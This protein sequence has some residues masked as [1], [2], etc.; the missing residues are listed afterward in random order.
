MSVEQG[1]EDFIFKT[2]YAR[3]FPHLKRR[4]NWSET[5]DRIKNMHL[6]KY[7]FSLSSNDRTEI[8]WAFSLVKDKIVLPSMRTMQFGGDAMFAH[9]ARGY[10]C[11]AKDTQFI[12]SHGVATFADFKDGDNIVVL[13][14][15]GKWRKATVKSYGLDKL[16]PIDITRSK[17]TYKVLATKDHTW[18]LKNGDKTTILEEGNLL[19]G[20][21]NIF[22]EFDY[23]KAE[24]DERLYWAYGYIYGDGTLVKK[25]D[26]TYKGSMVRLCKNDQQYQS[27]FEELGFSTSQPLSCDGDYM[28]YTGSY[29]KT[30]P[31]PQIDEPRLI[32][33]FVRGYLDADGE[34]NT[35]PSKENNPFITI[36]SSELDHISFIRQCFPIAGVYITSETD[37]TGQVT[38]Y[39]IRPYTISFSIW[40]Q[41]H[42]LSNSNN[43]FRVKSIGEPI[44]DSVWCLEV[45]EDKSFVLANGLVTGNCSVRH[46]DSLRACAEVGYLMLCGCGTGIGL[47][48]KFLARLPDL[49]KEQTDTVVSYVI[50]DTIEGWADSLEALL[51]S[52]FQNNIFSGRSITFDYSKIRRK[53]SILKTGGGKAPGARPLKIAHAKIKKLFD[54]LV[55]NKTGRA[56][57][58]HIYDALMYFADAVLSGGIR[59][60]ASAIVFD[61]DD[62]EMIQAKSSILVDKFKV[63]IDEEEGKAHCRVWK[64]GLSK[65][66]ILDVKNNAWDITEL[67]TNKR[68]SWFHI[69]P[70]RARSNNSIRLIRGQV[71]FDEFKRIFEYTRQFG[72][73]G[74][75]FADNEDVLFNPCYEIGFIPVLGCE[76]GVQFCNLTTLNATK[77]K[78]MHDFKEAVIA[79]SIIGTLQAGYTDFPY[80]NKTAKTLTEDEALLGCSITGIFENPDIFL[81]ANTLEAMMGE[82]VSTNEEWAKKLGIKPAAR[83][84]AIK[85]EGTGSLTIGVQGP[86]AHAVHSPLYWKRIQIDQND[87]I[88]QFFKVYNPDFCEKSVWNTNGTDDVINFPIKAKPGSLFKA[89]VSALDHLEV[90]KKLQ[91][92][93]VLPGQKNNQK[94]VNN[95]VSCTVLVKED[96]W[97]NV[98]KYVYDNNEFYSA[99]SFLPDNGDKIYA[100]APFET[101]TKEQVNSFEELRSKF[102]N[103]D[104]DKLVE[105]YDET[106][107]TSES[108]CSGG[109]CLI[110]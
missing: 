53:G 54:N 3:W 65:E 110:Q 19:L 9:N 99:V 21:Q 92:H 8:E 42:N 17:S 26:G 36:Q 86:G 18:F 66:V 4:E 58:I 68:I 10:N 67:K 69:E 37:L 103:P 91:K 85:P 55:D 44:E 50:D 11:L 97:D 52:Y 96:E 82:A 90:I 75:V 49:V 70:Q 109:A 27:R 89:D 13:S 79:C 88:Y 6:K 81:D 31:N 15:T 41:P 100:Q 94:D 87:N 12:T 46:I 78:S 1:L 64:N 84:G 61:K 74:F 34:K 25:E 60:T 107:H 47:G 102:I 71:T 7:A 14:H 63:V 16:Y 32:R 38:N 24:W 33:A 80:L 93:W 62:D 40:A 51:M 59:R 2:K 72:E 104:Y 45:E 95:S 98:I 23:N 106:S 105:N 30:A 76:C 56:R 48:K 29:M 108:S 39:G 83:V 73:P 28:A 5:V 57:P 22:N 43:S 101:V 77:I 20:S 35:N